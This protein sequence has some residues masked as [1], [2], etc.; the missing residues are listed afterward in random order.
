MKALD[1]LQKLFE[2]DFLEILKILKSYSTS[3][4]LVG[5]ATRDFLISSIVSRDL[6]I[7]VHLKDISLWDKLTLDLEKIAEVKRL[8][9]K[10]RSLIYK[11][12]EFELTLPRVEVF[13]NT[14]GHK[15]FEASFPE[16]IAPEKSFARRDFTL[17]A[18]GYDLINNRL[19]DPF[20]GAVDLKES[21]LKPI[22]KNFTKDPVR[23]IRG[24]R[25]KNNLSFKYDLSF[26]N[27]ID[28][29]SLDGL[30]AH[31]LIKE[32]K[33]TQ[34]WNLFFKDLTDLF[35]GFIV[36]KLV[37]KILPIKQPVLEKIHLSILSKDMNKDYIEFFGLSEKSYRRMI[38]TIQSGDF[39]SRLKKLKTKE[40]KLVMS[41]LEMNS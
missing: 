7:E 3:S 21:N 32:L 19:V 18:I 31:A 2:E 28:E 37:K 11:D 25:F 16:K 34:D 4:Y 30:T 5:G 9:F 35:P 40:Q 26:I 17:N 6:D 24:L 10:I 15:N 23:F 13:Q 27:L 38:D 14:A 8:P 1:N 41:F 36:S 29:H 12:F 22:L 39:D 33:K 20:K